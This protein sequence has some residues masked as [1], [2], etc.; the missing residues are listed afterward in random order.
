MNL[1]ASANW[2]PA[3][4]LRQV[5]GDRHQLGRQVADRRQQRRHEPRIEP[6]EMQVR[7]VNDRAHDV[8]APGRSRAVTAAGCGSSS[9]L[10]ITGHLAVEGDAQPAASGRV[11][12]AARWRRTIRACDVLRASERAP[13]RAAPADPV[14]ARAARGTRPACRRRA[15][16]APPRSR[17]SIWYSLLP[18]KRNAVRECDRHVPRPEPHDQAAIAAQNP[19]ASPG[20]RPAICGSPASAASRARPRCQG[21]RQSRSC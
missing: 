6:A 9:G 10:V 8:T 5:A 4:P 13:A 21:R 18:T 19:R 1:R 3:R 14:R 20:R 2:R 11:D 17:P 15:W 16:R 12:F 7:Q